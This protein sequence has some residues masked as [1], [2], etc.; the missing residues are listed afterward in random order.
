MNFRSPLSKV[1]E[2]T[3][4][5]PLIFVGSQDTRVLPES[6]GIAFYKALRSQQT[7][8]VSLYHYPHE[9]HSIGSLD[10]LEHMLSKSV[11]WFYKNWH[12]FEESCTIYEKTTPP[13][14]T[15]KFPDETT[16]KRPIVNGGEDMIKATFVLILMQVLTLRIWYTFHE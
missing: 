2:L 13:V 1:H 7:S 8:P 6:Q 15:T 11:G 4:F 10:S 12:V 14:P 3:D 9:G 5:A 16:T